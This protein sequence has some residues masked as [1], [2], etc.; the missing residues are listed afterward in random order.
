MVRERR[1]GTV[2]VLVKE[3]GRGLRVGE[4]G[5]VER[6]VGG[7]GRDR[8]VVL[9]HGMR[10][11]REQTRRGLT[12][13]RRRRL[14][15]IGVVRVELSIVRVELLLGHPVLFGPKPAVVV[16]LVLLL[17]LIVALGTVAGLLG[18]KVLDGGGPTG[19]RGEISRDGSRKG[20][21]ER[22]AGATSASA[23]IL[24]AVAAKS[25]N[26]ISQ[27]R[28]RGRTHFEREQRSQALEVRRTLAGGP[29]WSSA[30]ESRR[31]CLTGPL[32][33]LERER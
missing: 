32:A 1:R 20:A 26:R 6:R 22:S 18:A 9:V 19:A 7:V 10:G 5:Q 30:D 17:V 21:V 33:D 4:V 3:H 14:V 29:S 24:L 15:V 16:R 23:A 31:F 11:V 28:Q 2:L 12:P 25:G 8:R 27:N 13:L